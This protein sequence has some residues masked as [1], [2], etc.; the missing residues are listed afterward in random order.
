MHETIAISLY[1]LPLLFFVVA[2]IYS[3]VGLG[4][5]SAYTALMAMA[6]MNAL[7]IPMV[8][9]VLNLFVS[10]TASINFI[11]NGHARTTIIAP[12]ILSSMPMAYLGGSLNIA[13]NIFYGVLLVSLI[14]VAARIYFWSNT[15]VKL[16]LTPS[17][18]LTISLLAGS[19]L[20]LVAGI[21]GIGG[22]IYLV[23]LIIIL[24]LGTEKQ[25]AA[26]GAIFIWLNS[27]TGLLSRIQHNSIDISQ[28][29]PLILAVLV[30]GFLGSFMGSYRLSAKKME[31]VLGLVIIIAIFFLLNKLFSPQ[32]NA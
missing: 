17:Q 28:Y 25:A 19:V 12:F 10:T 7:A 8:S 1:W 3:S 15:R 31:K 16:N 26:S 22:G 20:G 11:R 9:L 4:G 24:G 14:F 13:P 32:I 5:G 18:K 27:L 23:P 30:G 21:V 2:F 29:Y 6:G